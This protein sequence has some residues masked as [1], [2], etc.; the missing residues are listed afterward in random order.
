MDSDVRNAYVTGQC[1]LYLQ[2]ELYRKETSDRMNTAAREARGMLQQATTDTGSLATFDKTVGTC[3]A[4]VV[5]QLARTMNT[6]LLR[7]YQALQLYAELRA[8]RL[9]K[10]REAQ[11]SAPHQAGLAGNVTTNEREA[12]ARPTVAE[13]VQQVEQARSEEAAQ[14]GDVA[15]AAQGAAAAPTG[16]PTAAPSEAT[17]KAG[18]KAAGGA[19][20]DAAAQRRARLRRLFDDEYRDVKP[21]P[22]A[23]GAQPVAQDS[24]RAQKFVDDAQ[25]AL[26]RIEVARA[27]KTNPERFRQLARRVGLA[28]VMLARSQTL[29]FGQELSALYQMG[30]DLIV[31]GPDGVKGFLEKHSLTHYYKLD[32]SEHLYDWFDRL[33]LQ[34]KE[35]MRS[36]ARFISEVRGFEFLFNNE[37]VRSRLDSDCEMMIFNGS[38]DGLLEWINARRDGQQDWDPATL[39]SAKFSLPGLIYLLDSALAPKQLAGWLGRLRDFDPHPNAA[40]GRPLAL[41]P[42]ILSPALSQEESWRTGYQ[43]A[44]A[45]DAANSAF[46][47]SVYVLGP[48][49]VVAG[50]PNDP[51]K[52]TRPMGFYLLERLIVGGSGPD[53]SDKAGV[54]LDRVND[55][56]PQNFFSFTVR[57]DSIAKMVE[58]LLK[59]GRRDRVAVVP[60]EGAMWLHRVSVLYLY[61]RYC[62]P[63]D[64]PAPDLFAKVFGRVPGLSDD[65]Y[66]TRATNRG[67]AA[68][69][70]EVIG[71]PTTRYSIAYLGNNT[72]TLAVLT[73]DNPGEEVTFRVDGLKR[74]FR[75]DG[76]F[77]APQQK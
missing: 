63:T 72:Y 26:R 55:D 57:S 32:R 13:V 33:H 44:L 15:G 1:G 54:L 64:V 11:A 69:A 21:A 47:S 75:T 67:G 71:R 52:I 49:Q 77:P 3:V 18:S 76:A 37:S 6:D 7:Q 35:A 48:A 19:P 5:E 31:Y 24:G 8:D 61:A 36:M 41:P 27:D 29:Q 46:A 14:S 23:P 62:V 56:S 74:I 53:A 2:A 65:A 22:A 16:A 25:E 59:K 34:T 10:R 20:T 17:G 50:Q 45:A 70:L 38:A 68:K 30:L 12:V 73:N 60:L 58:E 40:H 42:V 43:E 39:D 9:T 51:A 66:R 4:G 28:E